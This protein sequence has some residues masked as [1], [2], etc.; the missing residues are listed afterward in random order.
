M[1]PPKDVARSISSNNNEK[2]YEIYLV[3]LNSRHD[4]D[5]SLKDLSSADWVY[6]MPHI[7]SEAQ[8]FDFALFTSHTAIVDGRAASSRL[9]SVPGNESDLDVK[10]QSPKGSKQDG[11]QVPNKP[12]Y[13]RS[14]S[15]EGLEEEAHLL[16]SVVKNQCSQ[17][18]SEWRPIIFVAYGLGGLVVK[19]AMG[20]ANTNPRYY[21]IALRT[22]ELASLPPG[23]RW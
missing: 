16:L 15:A 22:K 20:I 5:A 14:C 21:D 11:L 2:I 10:G 7:A 12:R 3:G 9:S 1:S 4:L 8:V 18:K 19:R 6:L 17:S 23:P 13:E